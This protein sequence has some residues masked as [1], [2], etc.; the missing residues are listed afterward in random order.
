MKAD[1]L[2]QGYPRQYRV[3]ASTRRVLIGIGIVL[4]SFFVMMSA[5]RIAGVMKK[6]LAAGDVVADVVSATWAFWI[7]AA[8]SRR[9]ILNENSIEVIGWF[10]R[11]KLMREEIRGYKRVRPSRQAGG[12]SIYIVVPIDGHTRELKLPPFLHCNRQ[13]L[14]ISGICV[15]SA[16]SP[17]RAGRFASAPVAYSS[18]GR[19]PRTSRARWGSNPRLL[20]RVRS[21]RT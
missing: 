8:A 2:A 10:T 13:V 14:A 19:R 5:L 15:D 9:V 12:G 6:P 7:S 3:D 16:F 4:A 11:R 17:G 21:Q 20:C 18:S 1:S